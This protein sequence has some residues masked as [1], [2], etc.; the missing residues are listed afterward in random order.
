MTNE[1]QM[2]FEWLRFL[3]TILFMMFINL[4]LCSLLYL[5]VHKQNSNVFKNNL[6]N[7][8]KSYYF[9]SIHFLI[10]EIIIKMITCNYTLCRKICMGSMFG[11]A[12]NSPFASHITVPGSKYQ[13]H[14]WSHFMLI[15]TLGS[16]KDSTIWVTAIHIGDS[17]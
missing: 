1:N 10:I 4:S 12:V 8:T 16:K 9:S 7:Y 14:Y 6:E 2:A 17:D 13:L 15:C 11:T 3:S 5:T